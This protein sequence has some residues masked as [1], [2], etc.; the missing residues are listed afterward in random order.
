M[1]FTILSVKLFSRQNPSFTVIIF[2]LQY[3]AELGHYLHSVFVVILASRLYLSMGQ[4][5]QRIT[6]FITYFTS[7]TIQSLNLTF[8]NFSKSFSENDFSS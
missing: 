2:P 3:S 6:F 4:D 7:P 5:L 8:T 1:H